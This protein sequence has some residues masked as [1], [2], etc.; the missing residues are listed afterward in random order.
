[1]STNYTER[2]RRVELD[3]DDLEHKLYLHS[4]Y[5][6]SEDLQEKVLSHLIRDEN[7]M[8]LYKGIIKPQYFSN[9]RNSRLAQYAVEWHT[10]YKGR[11][12]EMDEFKYYVKLRNMGF[13]A[14][15]GDIPKYYELIE[16]L[17][18]LEYNPSYL[19]TIC[20]DFARTQA[21][22]LVMNDMIEGVVRMRTDLYDSYASRIR[23]AAHIGEYI[24]EEDIDLSEDTDEFLDEI[25]E[26]GDGVER[27]STGL[28]CFDSATNGGVGKGELTV[29]MGNS[30]RG[31]TTLGQ[32]ILANAVMQGKNVLH[33]SLENNK[34]TI[35]LNYLQILTGA[36]RDELIKHKEEYK[37]TLKSM[38]SG[39]KSDDRFGRLCI[40]QY[41]T[42]GITP[43]ALEAKLE[44]YKGNGLLFDEL[45]I[46]YPSIMA[47][48]TP[49]PN[50]P[51]K[52]VL[53]NYETVRGIAL[54]WNC[55][56]IAPAQANRGGESKSA[57]SNDDL[58]EAYAIS[59]I[60][61]VV[62]ASAMSDAEKERGIV[63]ISFPKVRDGE[64]GKV[65]NGVIDWHTKRLTLNDWGSREELE[66][67]KAR[68]KRK[69]GDD[70]GWGGIPD[71]A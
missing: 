25:A 7:G 28:Q 13:S 66:A 54:R 8:R 71:A 2:K 5:K 17:Y 42:R 27:I 34:K 16:H 67:P 43:S 61:D 39:E 10:R 31:K 6:M 52:E 37:D 32:N 62:V 19:D 24:G 15:A 12:P 33:V 64:S 53:L 56:T 50:A 51:H 47:P 41:P 18:G 46:D 30:G 36:S 21:V 45:M 23:E 58:A 35:A 29:I 69:E 38:F 3:S 68:R 14:Q 60:A 11:A 70:P 49:M 20:I 55:A 22:F 59:N 4:E 1:M 40:L 26:K 44:D 48:E 65:A 63:H 57:L 9:A